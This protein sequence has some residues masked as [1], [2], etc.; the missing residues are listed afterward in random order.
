MKFF[1][2]LGGSV[3]FL[4]TFFT[5]LHA[6]SEV[7]YAL[8]DGAIGCLAGAFLLRGFHH[9]IMLCIKSLVL[10]QAGVPAGAGRAKPS[11]AESQTI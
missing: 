5:E 3:G 9:V 1:L 4:A 10:E 2:V 6:G 8:R 11:A 7:G